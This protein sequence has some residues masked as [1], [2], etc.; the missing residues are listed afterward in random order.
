M[1]N[2]SFLSGKWGTLWQKTLGAA[3]DAEILRTTWARRSRWPDWAPSDALLYI[4]AERG[5]MEQALIMGSGGQVEAESLWRTRLRQAWSTWQ[6]S[7]SQ[8]AHTTA[9]ATTG[10]TNAYVQ[11]RVDLDPAAYPP[12][13]AAS[14]YVQAFQRSVWAQFDIFVDKPHPWVPVYWG[15]GHKWNDP[16]NLWTWGSSATQ[17]EVAHL[18]RLARR[19]RS[20]HDT[21]T[22]INVKLQGGPYFWGSWHWGDG[23][24]WGPG[25]FAR[26]LV[27]ETH[28]RLRGLA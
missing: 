24:I 26:W 25:V 22:W 3:W 15:D 28:W 19:F 1:I 9:F 13:P 12:T 23:S 18:Q 11:R 7:G 21:C 27:G 6:L 14:A 10:L 20:G 17:Q 8:Q 2:R 16:I 5:G 4:G